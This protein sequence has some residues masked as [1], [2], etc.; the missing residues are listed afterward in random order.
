[1][2]LILHKN[3]MNDYAEECLLVAARLEATNPVR[4]F[5]LCSRTLQ[6]TPPQ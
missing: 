6:F 2:G 5:A 3:G 1:M 4:P